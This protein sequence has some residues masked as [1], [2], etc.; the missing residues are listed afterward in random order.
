MSAAPI[1]PEGT[2][3]TQPVSWRGHSG[4]YYALRRDSLEDFHLTGDSLFV[5]G[6]GNIALWVGTADDVIESSERRT[7]FKA[8]LKL[9]SSVMRYDEPL[10]DVDRMT[11]AWDIENGQFAA[12]LRLVGA[13]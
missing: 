5:L 7:A 12:K 10:E 8:A 2:D 1:W 11:T 3:L 4:R 6:A 9:C 13:D